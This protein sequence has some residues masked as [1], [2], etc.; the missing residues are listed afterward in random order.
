MA[1]K[2]GV[3]TVKSVEVCNI[4][5]R[6]GKKIKEMWFGMTSD[7]TIWHVFYN[8]KLISAYHAMGYYRKMWMGQWKD[9]KE[10]DKK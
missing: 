3:I 2:C 8:I 10:D 4:K 6:D 5:K 1:K 7:G 9:K